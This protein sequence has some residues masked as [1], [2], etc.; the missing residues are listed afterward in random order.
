MDD[1]LPVN[2]SPSG[3]RAWTV[4]AALAAVFA[5]ACAL[6]APIAAMPLERDEGEYAYIAQRWLLGEVPYKSAFDQKPPGAFVAY[7]VFERLLGTSPAALHWGTQ[8]YTLGTLAVLFFLGRRMF[9]PLVGFLAALFAAFLTADQGVLGNAANTE[10]FMLLPLAGAMLTTLRAVEDD[11][12]AWAVATGLL[13]AAALLCKQVALPHVAFYFGVLL[14]LGRRHWALAAGML[15][16]LGVGLLPVVAYFAAT[17]AWGD[18]LD[19]ILVYNLS[20]VRTVPLWA[21]PQRFWPSFRA[22]LQT[23][24]PVYLLALAGLLAGWRR[25]PAR[26]RGGRLAALW[27]AVAGVAVCIGGY[28]FQ[29][30]F[31]HPIPP[32]AL[33]AAVGLTDL[34]G[35]VASGRPRVVLAG[36][37]AGLAIAFGVVRAPEYYLRG[38][39]AQKCR[40]LYVLHPFPESVE[41]ARYVAER[42]GPDDPI[43]VFG[44]EPQIY[45]YARRKCSSRYI[46]ANAWRYPSPTIRERQEAVLAEVR[47]H[48]PR[49]LIYVNIDL[50]LPSFAGQPDIVFRG[51][52]PLIEE[53][54]RVVAVVAYSR[55]TPMPLLRKPP[56]KR[57]G[58]RPLIWIYERV[59][60]PGGG[61][62]ATEPGPV[63]TLPRVLKTWS[64]PDLRRRRGNV[65]TCPHIQATALGADSAPPLSSAGRLLFRVRAQG[66]TRWGYTI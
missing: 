7:L 47:A 43:F 28:F 9:S 46:Y 62:V 66:R 61:H 39:P 13:G 44:S 51:L 3:R 33:L 49:F 24:G 40:A 50:S 53:S 55:E 41:V 23:A 22:L 65:A 26:A 35:L 14:W 21:Y 56:W 4:A 10:I 42:S 63:A 30:Y 19:C 27:L 16:G 36:V 6:R 2:A 38:S 37:T 64:R 45:Y 15:L 34:L 5:L 17:G 31:M 25:G 12:V 20:H 1:L 11:S 48:P 8:I 32:V 29:H 57:G 58:H 60:R 54:Y 18:F 52:R 59:V